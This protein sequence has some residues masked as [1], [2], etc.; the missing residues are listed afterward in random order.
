MTEEDAGAARKN[1]TFTKDIYTLQ[2]NDVD[3]L[4]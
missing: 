2:K 3:F 1:F 4:V